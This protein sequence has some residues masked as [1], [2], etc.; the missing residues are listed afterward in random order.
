MRF[1]L[2]CT[3]A[4]FAALTVAGCNCDRGLNRKS[5]VLVLSRETVDFGTVQI[6]LVHEQRVTVR[7]DGTASLTLSDPSIAAPFGITT[8]LPLTL[9]LGGEAELV[10]TYAPTSAGSP[11]S[12]DFTFRTDDPTHVTASITLRGQGIQAV[13]QVTPNPVDFGDVYAGESKQLTV[14]L[15][16]AGTNDL[17]PLDVQFSPGTAPQFSG[18]LAPLKASLK[19]GAS[20]Q[21]TV[22]LAPPDLGSFN[23]A[24]RFTFDALQGG[25]VDVPLTGRGIRA[26]PQLCFQFTGGGEVCTDPDAGSGPGSAINIP[27]GALCDNVLFPPGS[28]GGCT[29]QN[30]ERS[31]TLVVKNGGNVPFKF[32]A[33]YA[34][35]AAGNKNPCDA[36]TTPIPDFQFSN[37]PDAGVAKFSAPTSQLPGAVTDPRPWQTAPI[38]ITY[39]ATSR[40]PG[41]SADQ[42]NVILT[43]QGEPATHQP[44]LLLATFSGSSALPDA[45][46]SSVSTN[47][48]ANQLPVSIP[49]VGTIN[50]GT[51]SM[52]VNA[53]A[54]YEELLDAGAGSGP[55]GGVLVACGPTPPVTSECSGFAWSTDG[56]DPNLR[57]PITVLPDDGGSNPIGA[58]VFGP[59]GADCATA[60]C[61]NRTYKVYAL[62]DTSDPYHARVIATVTATAH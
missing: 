32:S 7:N 4:A 19:A 3:L 50:R 43:R 55:N 40:C 21:T 49:F 48:S 35:N 22:T 36:G 51:A 20:A 25:V 16:N 52:D 12:T 34:Q 13:A 56:G 6:N 1:S 62:I 47:P 26:M 31:G 46:P 29:A 57:T 18:D 60:V 27:F 24:I 9:E 37:A 41:D 38:T 30:G 14:K 17:S 10:F 59:N 54:L 44:T 58:L 33:D 8:P 45:Q 28:D 53:V 23:G 61:P 39:R 42:A 5:P 15:T 11:N 2:L